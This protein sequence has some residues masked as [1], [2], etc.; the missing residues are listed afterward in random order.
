MSQG[1]ER[2]VSV[3]SVSPE[4]L[5]TIAPTVQFTEGAEL[6]QND[7]T[8]MIVADLIANPEGQPTPFLLA[9][10]TVKATYSFTDP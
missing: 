7:P 1:K 10:Q 2:S 9:G 5:L 8:G 4:K 6:K 3:F